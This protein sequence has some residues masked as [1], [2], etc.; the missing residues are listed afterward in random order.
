[1][2]QRTGKVQPVTTVTLLTLFRQHPHKSFEACGIRQDELERQAKE[3]LYETHAYYRYSL[4]RTRSA[5][6]G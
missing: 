3:D 4:R 6:G 2:K 5:T 1:M